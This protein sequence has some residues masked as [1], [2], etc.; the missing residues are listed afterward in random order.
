MCHPDV[1]SMLSSAP[2]RSQPEKSKSAAFTL[3]ELLVVIA[4]IAILA[5]ILFPVFAQAREKAR[6]ISCLSNMKQLGLAMMQY[7][8]D[9]DGTYPHNAG[10]PT[11]NNYPDINR[12]GQI[13][14]FNIHWQQQIF[15]YN[16]SWSIYLCP[17]DPAPLGPKIDN[18][19]LSG[20]RPPTESS[21]A[22]NSSLFQFGEVAGV[23][24]G[25]LSESVLAS[26]A[27]T[28]IISE[29][30]GGQEFFGYGGSCNGAGI[31]RLNR[32]R[33]ANVM[34]NAERNSCAGGTPDPTLFVGREDSRTRHQGGEN[35]VYAD[36]HAKWSRWQNIKDEN[37][38]INPERSAGQPVTGFCIN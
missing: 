29:V 34:T 15:P 13:Y 4:I 21:Y 24:A 32:V 16:K 11:I 31:S 5:A 35:I 25:S 14:A 2:L 17:S 12:K 37:T 6:S 27:S 33:F 8:Q 20:Y 30:G 36:G 19:G 9:Y 1:S 22:I 23:R 10:N 38:C 3:I 18:A 28:Y 7:V 26:P